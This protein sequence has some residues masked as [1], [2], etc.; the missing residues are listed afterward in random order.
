[1]E[2]RHEGYLDGR[3]KVMTLH[4]VS[5]SACNNI[6]EHWG[7]FIISGLW[8]GIPNVSGFDISYR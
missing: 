8:F 1:M 4:G 6:I 5:W 7:M 3:I 2:R